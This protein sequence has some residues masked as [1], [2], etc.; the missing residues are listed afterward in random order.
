VRLKR[1]Y[2]AD[3]WNVPYNLSYVL[4]IVI[5]LQHGFDLWSID[6][7]M[8]N[9]LQAISVLMIWLGLYY[10]MRLFE[11]LAAYVNLIRETMKDITNFIIL[12]LMCIC[13]FA[14]AIYCLDVISDPNEV[15]V[16]PVGAE[17]CEP[18]ESGQLISPIYSSR[19]VNTV[20]N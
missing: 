13:M 19:A 1:Q 16:T 12:F 14:N 10:W 3:V 18:E 5:L 6:S 4:N 15:E 7:V 17:Y 20:I 9:N 11:G 8:M 2:L